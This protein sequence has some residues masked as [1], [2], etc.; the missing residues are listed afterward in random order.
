MKIVVQ[1]VK[2]AQVN[3]AGKCV[4]A[5]SQGLVVLL[6]VHRD[7][8]DVDL[9]SLVSRLV[10]MRIFSGDDDK[11]NLSLKEIGGEFLVVSQF[12]LYGR[13]KKGTRPG[14]SESAPKEKA[15]HYYNHFVKK[16]QDCSGSK[17]ETG[18]F[19]ADMELH[20]V[21]E[22]PVTMVLDSKSL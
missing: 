19:A 21:N 8:E 16:L 20:L 13:M 22:G 18:V 12:T 6:A 3:V 1:R 10:K 9:D 14:F 4:G 11:M 2:S 17:V 7:D 15:I 5:I